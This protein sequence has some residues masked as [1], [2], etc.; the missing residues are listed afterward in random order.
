MDQLSRIAVFVE[1]VRQGGFAGAAR[2]LGITGSAVSKQIQ[3]LEH[4]LK[5]KLLNRTTRRVSVTEEGAIFFERSSRALEDLKEAEEHINEMKLSPR[6]PL[7]VSVPLSFGLTHLA[8]PIADFA[9]TYPD[10]ELDVHF[11]DRVID[12]VQEEF[13]VCV[14]IGALTDSS[15]ISR[16]LGDCPFY[17]CASPAYLKKN[18]MPQAPQDLA[19]HNV[20]AY[21]R[22]R[23]A[24]EWRYKDPSGAVGQVGLKS[25]FKCDAGEMMLEAAKKDLGVIILPYFY[26]QDAVANG[27]LICILEDHQTWPERT[28]TA[29]FQPNRYLSTRLRLFVDHLSVTCEALHRP[30][31]RKKR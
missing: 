7:K 26:V 5:V 4:D 9:R 6:G 19:R 28:I 14:R 24:H 20:L 27:D 10:V 18:G 23:G 17:I 30:P 12:I 8:G 31:G 13:D 3:N 25:N 29:I 1:V 11:D 15:L 16:K 22:N 21:T 2:V